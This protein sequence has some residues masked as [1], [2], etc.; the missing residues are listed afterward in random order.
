MNIGIRELKAA[1]IPGE[2]IVTKGIA[3][4]NLSNPQMHQLI[5]RPIFDTVLCARGV[6]SHRL[7]V[8]VVLRDSNDFVDVWRKVF[9]EPPSGPELGLLGRYEALSK[10]VLEEVFKVVRVAPQ[11]LAPPPAVLPTNP[12]GQSVTQ[13][14][15]PGMRTTSSPGNRWGWDLDESRQPSWL[16]LRWEEV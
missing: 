11:P 16:L 3:Q 6:C 9:P 5:I 10:T 7:V 4:K 1:G 13:D 12:K 2:V 8:E 15:F 14:A